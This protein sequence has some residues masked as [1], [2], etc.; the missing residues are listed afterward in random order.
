MV[1]IQLP[2]Q[3]TRD[4]ELSL[5][6]LEQLANTAGAVAIE[7]IIQHKSNPHPR[8]FIGPG[9][10]REIAGL[11]RGVTGGMVIFD[12]E[13]SPSQQLHL[14]E[15]IDKKIVDRTGLILD[16][17]SQHAHSA[18]GKVQVELAQ[19]NY[20]LPRLRGLGIEMSRLGG[21]IGTRGPGETKLETDRRR[22]FKRVRQLERDLEQLSKI[23]DV[24]RQ[25]RKKREIF[26]VSLVGYT[27][28]G[29]STLLNKMTG[30]DVLV[31][32]KLF[33]TLDSTTRK[34]ELP[35]GKSA[36]ISDTVGFIKK[37]PHELI[38]AFKSTLDEVREARLI[39]HVIDASN[40][41]RD[42]QIGTV[43]RLLDELD[44]KEIPRI[45]VFNKCDL[46]DEK[47]VIS[48]NHPPETIAVSAETGHNLDKLPTLIE[49]KMA[50]DYRTV[51][52]KLPHD[53]GA[54]RKKVFDKGTVLMEE[55]DQEGSVI[56]A[57]IKLKD[58]K[59][60]EPYLLDS[61]S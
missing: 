40:P 12:D 44:I 26:T 56:T 43:N 7:K 58:L 6:E 9:K 14:E 20:Y 39:L 51:I 57:E 27:N 50:P 16:I 36:T 52:L 22:L 60:F 30:A 2:G 21:G 35:S 15:L 28:T 48:L 38:A 29:K 17:F 49:A 19:L 18:E 24:Q 55:S 32:N 47:E 4:L 42:K 1:A 54:V 10:A 45:K 37:L 31:E 8:T 61:S 34:L 59:L 41:D 5:D 11:L 33:A 25:R 23:R 13:L 3:K 53:S 46:I